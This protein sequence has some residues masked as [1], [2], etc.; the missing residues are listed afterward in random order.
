MLKQLWQGYTAFSSLNLLKQMSNKGKIK[1]ERN[2]KL[3]RY[4]ITYTI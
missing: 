2:P 1:L 3:G 4:N